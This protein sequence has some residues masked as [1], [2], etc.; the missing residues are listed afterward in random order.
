MMLHKL[1]TGDEVFRVNVGEENVYTFTV[2]DY[3]FNEIMTVEV[4]GGTPLGGSLSSD[5]NA[6]YTFVWTPETSP[7]SALSFVATDDLGAS[8]M[9]TPFLQVCA[10]F[11]GGECTEKGVPP[12]I[13]A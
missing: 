9:L 13:N 8:A 4:Q 7:T 2:I 11:N 3:T 6:T 12:T 1:A 10:C 5:G